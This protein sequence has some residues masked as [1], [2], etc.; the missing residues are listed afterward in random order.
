[1]LHAS[2][3]ALRKGGSAMQAV[4]RS[5]FRRP[6][7]RP[8]AA[9]LALAAGLALLA[10]GGCRKAPDIP[11]P[12]DRKAAAADPD[13]GGSLKGDF[14][15]PQGKEIEAVLTSPPN[16]PPPVNRDYPAKVVVELDVVEKEMPI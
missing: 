8:V 9:A 7:S 16:V 5:P 10:A 13:T 12:Q 14:G 3:P 2:K 4:V 6:P 1:M 15:P 11:L